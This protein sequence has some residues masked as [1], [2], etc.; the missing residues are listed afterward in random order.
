MCACSKKIVPFYLSLL[1]YTT[2]PICINVIHVESFSENFVC[3]GI[4]GNVN[5]E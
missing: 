1:A 4:K 3:D 5:L 2:Y